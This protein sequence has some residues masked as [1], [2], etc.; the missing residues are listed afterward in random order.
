MGTWEKCYTE[1]SH[2]SI[3][4]YAPT[5]TDPKLIGS[6]PQLNVGFKREANSQPQARDLI[7]HSS[8]EVVPPFNTSTG[9]SAVIA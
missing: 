5:Y 6:M 7:A 1:K 3:I 8:V 4:R 2:D 9:P